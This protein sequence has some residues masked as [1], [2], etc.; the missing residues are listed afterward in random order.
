MNFLWFFC[1]HIFP[2]ECNPSLEIDKN[3]RVCFDWLVGGSVPL[4]LQSLKKNSS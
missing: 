2:E 4:R 3:F 1:G